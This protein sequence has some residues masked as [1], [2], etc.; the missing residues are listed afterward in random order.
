MRPP[1]LADKRF[2]SLYL[3]ERF[4]SHR[5]LD[6]YTKRESESV[7]CRDPFSREIFLLAA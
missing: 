7:L 5:V 3:R 4:L 6:D 2:A 1:G